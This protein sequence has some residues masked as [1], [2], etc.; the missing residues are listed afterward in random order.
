M[1]KYFALALLLIAVH[2]KSGN[3][4]EIFRQI[5]DSLTP[6]LSQNN[7][8]DFIDFMESHM[9]AEVRNR[10]GG[11]SEMTALTADSLSIRMSEALRIDMLLLTPVEPV[12]S[13]RQV[14]CVVST[15]GT[16]SLGLES[17]TVYFSFYEDQLRQV[18]KADPGV[19]LGMSLNGERFSSPR[20]QLIRNS[21]MSSVVTRSTRLLLMRT[22][23]TL[24]ASLSFSL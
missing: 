18:Y 8:L 6:Y 16:D 14:V 12:D 11:I 5:P 10:L 9:K 17:R 15:Y 4:E 7:R 20:A 19:T 24:L 1:R 22:N 13:S 3:L 2:C 21:L 23:S